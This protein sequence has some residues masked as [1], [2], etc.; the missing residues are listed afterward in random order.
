MQ[1]TLTLPPLYAKQRAALFDPAPL[2]IIEAST[3]AGKSVGA[4]TWIL[5]RAINHSPGATHLWTEPVY[6]LAKVMFKRLKRMFTRA[7]TAKEYWSHNDTDQEFRLCNGSSIVFRG[8][9][10]PDTIYGPDY[11][12]AVVDEAS[13]TKE[14]AW[15]AVVSTT[16]ATRAP[17]RAIGNVRGRANWAYRL[18]QLAK[19]GEP[20]MA[21][22]RIVAQDAVD[23]GVLD[24]EYLALQ[25]R[26][27]PEHI[28]RELFECIPADDG[29]N[30]FGMAAIAACVGP[31][32][33]EPVAAWGIDLAKSVDWTVCI[34]LDA[35]GRVA[36]FERW[37]APWNV[38]E[39]RIVNLVGDAPALID[40][41][42][43]GASI[44]ERLQSRI[45]MVEGFT[46]TTNSKRELMGRLVGAVVGGEVGFPDGPIRLEMES[47]EYEYSASGVS[48]CAP[49][50]LHDD[51]VCALALARRKLDTL[52]FVG[53]YSGRRGDRAQDGVETVDLMREFRDRRSDPNWGF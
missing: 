50:G 24:A 15:T 52:P 12:A 1:L 42:G 11:A 21:Y 49:S 31:L 45:G 7:D 47:F 17:I 19:A 37:Q 2:S 39:A 27:L 25:R 32:S 41:T 14:D 3:K 43:V 18:G 51:C 10:R 36:A 28:Y 38:T 48:Y 29:G 6:P 26:R 4:L 44:V 40:D 8:S 46:F 30:P 23:A 34:G 9:D 35:A 20:G 22:H 53:V 5:D 16:T 13:R 33:G